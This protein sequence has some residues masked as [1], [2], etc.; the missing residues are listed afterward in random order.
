MSDRDL[1]QERQVAPLLL[2]SLEYVWGRIHDRQQGLTQAEYLWEPVPGCWSVRQVG[3]RWQAERVEPEP[4]P[5]PVKTIAWR[6]SH[7]GSDILASYTANGLGHWPLSVPESSWYGDV[8]DALMAL[9]QAWEAFRAGLGN[10][11]ESGMWRPLG[12]TWG[13]YAN[14]AWAALKGLSS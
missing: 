5:A 7:I 9:D 1:G 10:L 8:T 6:L 12:E 3:D 13:P 4:M 11:G 2:D 14:D